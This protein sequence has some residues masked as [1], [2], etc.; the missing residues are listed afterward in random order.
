MENNINNEPIKMVARECKFVVHLP[1]INGVRKDTHIVKEYLHYSD[2]SFKKNLRIVE[3]YRRPFWVT[4]PFYQK[5]KVKKESEE[6]SKLNEYT[7][8]ES[9]LGRNIASRLGNRYAGV[10]KK[11]DVI[12]SPFLYGT[13]VSAATIIKKS[14][15][16]K[17]PN[18][19][20]AYEYATLDIE[21]N[22]LDKSFGMDDGEITIVTLSMVD[23]SHTVVTKRYLG[24]QKNIKSR[25]EHLFNKYVPDGL[26]KKAKRSLDIVENEVELVKKIMLKAHEW[27]PDII[28]IWN[29]GFDLPKMTSV[30]EKAGIDPGTVFTD[31]K[32]PKNL[33]HYEYKE[34]MK[35]KVT[36]S[37]KYTPIKPE[38]QWHT[39]I[40][41]ASFFFIDAMSSHRYVRA[42]GKTMPGGY[43][44]DNILEQELGSKFKKLKFDEG[45]VKMKGIE[46]HRYMSST[47]PI[48]YIVYNMW[49]TMSMIE[50]D[51]KTKDLTTSL[52][53]LSGPSSFAIFNSGPKKI[54]DAM[55]FYYLSKGSVLGVKPS[56]INDDKILGLDDWI[57]LLPSHRITNNGLQVI[58]ENCDIKTNARGHTYDADITVI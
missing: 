56:K 21:T 32:L 27:E 45:E 43:S 31:P 53:M 22:T 12:D 18:H 19:I 2:G 11:R 37:G 49:D 34:G 38:E 42:G 50:L 40:I 3:N 9:D 28:G 52:P 23:K 41:P 39:A 44:L 54:V 16:D 15:M 26:A 5:N 29:I 10:T 8:T 20:T 17:Y 58:N 6:L 7:S 47:K 13:D 55:H 30:L 51:L 33:Q 48:E 1:K 25:I 24:N 57:I 4:K 36:E 35:Q 14:Y 46:W